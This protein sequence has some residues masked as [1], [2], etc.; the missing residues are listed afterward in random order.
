MR[1]F[2][3][4]RTATA[5]LLPLAFSLVA[6][7]SAR[8]QQTPAAQAAPAGPFGVSMPEW[9]GLSCLWGGSLGGLGCF[10]TAT[11]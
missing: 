10:I 4:C 3:H 8:A 7:P 6:A 11:Y 1:F 2:D 9:Q 5:A